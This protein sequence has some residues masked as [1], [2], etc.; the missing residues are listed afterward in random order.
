MVSAVRMALC[1]LCKKRFG[2]DWMN[3]YT[4]PISMLGSMAAARPIKQKICRPI[5]LLEPMGLHTE[6]GGTSK[7]FLLVFR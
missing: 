4:L 5:G 2:W 1:G 3:E 7:T 6:R